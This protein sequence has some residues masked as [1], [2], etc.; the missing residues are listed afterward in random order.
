MEVSNLDLKTIQ[1]DNKELVFD[2]SFDWFGK[3]L[4]VVTAER[5]IKIYEKGENEEWRKSGQ[6]VGHNSSI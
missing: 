1:T 6:F 3:R 5:K 2:M 4:A